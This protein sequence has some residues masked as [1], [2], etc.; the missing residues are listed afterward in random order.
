MRCSKPQAI[1]SARQRAGETPLGSRLALC[2]NPNDARCGKRGYLPKR[3]AFGLLSHL[4]SVT[5]QPSAVWFI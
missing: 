1:R 4:R 2:P 3:Q 5:V